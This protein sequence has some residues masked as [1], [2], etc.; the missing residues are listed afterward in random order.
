MGN[1]QISLD[2]A[3]EILHKCENCKHK[4]CFAHFDL[5]QKTEETNKTT[6]ELWDETAIYL[7]LYIEN[8]VPC[9]MYEKTKYKT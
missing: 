7:G 4:G 8:S 3:H 1:N 5:K 2:Y 9:I 6:V